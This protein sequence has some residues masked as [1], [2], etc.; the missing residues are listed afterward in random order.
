MLPGRR[1]MKPKRFL[2]DGKSQ[3]NQDTGRAVPKRYLVDEKCQTKQNTGRARQNASRWVEEVN[4]TS[5]GRVETLPGGQRKSSQWQYCMYAVLKRYR[6]AEPSSH[7]NAERARKNVTPRAEQNKPIKRPAGAQKHY[8][9][10]RN[11][12]ILSN[13]IRAPEA[14]RRGEANRTIVKNSKKR[15]ATQRRRRPGIIRSQ[16]VHRGDVDL[17]YLRHFSVVEGTKRSP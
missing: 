15:A 6:V 16:D 7:L 14:L 11:K 4:K 9:E 13:S 17:R 10:G 3:T 8:P 12:L 2:V 5:D 1:K